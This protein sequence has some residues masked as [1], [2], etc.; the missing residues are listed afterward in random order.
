LFLYGP[1]TAIGLLSFQG[2]EGGLTFPMNGVSTHW[3][4]ALF[5]QQRVGDFVGSFWRSLLL[6]LIVMTLSVSIGTMAG[7]A[8]RYCFRVP[9]GFSFLVI[10][11]FL[12]VTWY[13]GRRQGRAL[14]VTTTAEAAADSDPLEAVGPSAG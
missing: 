10:G 9:T 5:S 3:F 12:L 4:V 6:G 11:L 8:Y 7:L 1:L 13:L 14:L 2:P